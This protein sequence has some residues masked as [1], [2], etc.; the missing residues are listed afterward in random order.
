MYILKRKWDVWKK[1]MKFWI[2]HR[3]LKSCCVRWFETIKNIA[4]FIS[5]LLFAI[6]FAIEF[7]VQAL[8]VLCDV[9]KFYDYFLQ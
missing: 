7:I 6:D 3:K 5:S 2:D 8:Q 9:Y 1:G 4:V